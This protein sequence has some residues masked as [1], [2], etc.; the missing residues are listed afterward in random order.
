MFKERLLT[1]GPTTIPTEVLKAMEV[2]MLH[3]RSEDFKRILRSAC[4]GVKWV[5]GWPSDPVFLAASGTGALEASLLNT[6]SPGDQILYVNGGTFGARWGAIAERLGL[7]AHEI[8]VEWGEAVKLQQ[9]VDACRAHP[10]TKLLCLQHSET[11]TTALHPLASLLPVIKRDFPHILTVVD[12]ISASV[13]TPPPGDP[14]LIDI[15]VAGSQKAYML[16]P[17]LSFVLL[18]DRAWALVESTPKRSLY[19]DFLFERKAIAAGETKWT[20][21]ST[22]IVGL[23]AAIDLMRKEGLQSIYARHELLSK[24]TR[25]GLTSLGCRLLAPDAPCPSVT[26]FM[27]PSSSN[28]DADSLRVEIRKRF[29]IRLAGGQ[30]KWKGK[31]V[32]VGH[33]GFVDPFEIVNVITAIG[34][35]LTKLGAVVPTTLA[36]SEVIKELEA[37]VS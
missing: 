27:P 37:H 7:T 14:S 1:P 25:I 10:G 22:L 32:R 16:P 19:F 3:H 34:L 28:V 30:E 12:A 8:S 23:N 4:E 26:G 9:I 2:P 13:T 18:S 35:T 20:P 5:L 6:C 36:V 31:I 11:S 33:M 29:G 17:G 24:L 15:Y 21:A